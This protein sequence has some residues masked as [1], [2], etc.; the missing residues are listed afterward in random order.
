LAFSGIK[1][2]NKIRFEMM[3]NVRCLQCK[4]SI[5]KGVRFNAHKKCV[6]QYLS[7]KIYEFSMNC[8]LCENKFVVRT[9]PKN[10]DYVLVSGIEKRPETLHDS[11]E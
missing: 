8:H 9:D 1:N 3:F 4:N 6:D 5:G 2:P 11:S 7:T 10:C